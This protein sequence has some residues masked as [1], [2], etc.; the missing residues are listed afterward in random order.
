MY[1][2]ERKDDDGGR[3]GNH[4]IS[5]SVTDKLKVNEFDEDQNKLAKG[6]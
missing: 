2:T 4:L 5:N 6:P 1:G 3:L